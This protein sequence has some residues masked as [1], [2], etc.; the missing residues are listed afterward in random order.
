MSA[1]LHICSNKE[2]DA[3]QKRLKKILSR[4]PELW[5]VQQ[6]W[7]HWVH[8]N[9]KVRRAP[10]IHFLEQGIFPSKG[11][12]YVRAFIV[13]GDPESIRDVT[14]LFGDGKITAIGT[15]SEKVPIGDPKGKG[16]QQ[17]LKTEIACLEFI[18]KTK[19]RYIFMVEGNDSGVCN[20]TIVLPPK[21]Q[22]SFKQYCRK[23]AR[24]ISQKTTLRKQRL[25]AA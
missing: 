11:M 2:I 20:I 17:L 7:N 12:T 14:T 4:F 15:G 24:K 16:L 19:I 10:K 22:R 8:E 13:S 21:G 1:D 18:V 23:L 9:V 6:E 3:N 25:H 5:A